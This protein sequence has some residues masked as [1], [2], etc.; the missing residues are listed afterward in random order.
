MFFKLMFISFRGISSVFLFGVAGYLII[1]GCKPDP[2]FMD[3]IAKLLKRVALPCL[4]FSTMVTRFRIEDVELWWIYPLVAVAINLSGVILAYGYMGIDRSV[5]FRGEFKVLV[6][7]QNGIFLPLAFAPAL[8]DPQTLPYFLTLLFL[9]NL[10]SIPTFF[11]LAVWMVNASEGIRFRIRDFFSPPVAATVLGFIIAAAGWGSLMPEFLMKPM[12]SIGSLATPLSMLLVG[13]I[14]VIN[15]PK[16]KPGDWREPVKISFLKCFIF[17]LLACVFVYIVRPPEY[18][19]LLIILE[20][21]M[22]SAMLI[23]LIASDDPGKQRVIAGAILLTS[24]ICILTIPFF[25]GIYG[26]LYG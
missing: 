10:L 26:A 24:L 6:A 9:F 2:R 1:A 14:I 22:P 25:M 13:G 17:P 15:L 19:G 16:A 21:A 4:M 12:A 11:I 3:F 7:F 5:T 18:L 8:F 20:S 23:A